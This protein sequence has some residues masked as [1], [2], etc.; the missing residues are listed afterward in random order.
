MTSPH[1]VRVG[2]ELSPQ[3]CTIDEL[4]RGLA[5]RRRGGLRPRLGVRPPR[6]RSPATSAGAVFEGW[7]LLAAMAEVTERARIGLMVTGNTYRH[8]GLLAKMAVTV[9]HLSGGRL[10]FGAR[11]RVGRGRAHDAGPAVPGHRRADPPHGGGARADQEA[12]DRGRGRPRR[13]LLRAARRRREPEAGAAPAPADLGRRLGREGDAA[14]RRRAR[15]RAGTRAGP[16]SP[17]R[18]AS[19]RSSTSTAPPS[20]ATRRRSGARPRRCST[21]TT[22]RRRSRRSPATSMPASPRSCSASAA[23]DPVAAAE[24]AATEVLARVPRG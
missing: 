4:R 24:L 3:H 20:A 8:P 1:P 17:R 10:E 2:L 12:L 22:R 7:T 16:T 11:R 6:P 14:L 5:A 9:D 13:P 23:P 15:R 18:G 21:A 19:P